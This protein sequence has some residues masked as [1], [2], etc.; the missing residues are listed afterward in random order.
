MSPFLP[1]VYPDSVSLLP[2]TRLSGMH[3]HESEV[4]FHFVPGNLQGRRSFWHHETGTR[5]GTADDNTA[6]SFPGS[7]SNRSR[8]KSYATFQ[9]HSGHRSSCKQIVSTVQG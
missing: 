9:T 4:C 8:R 3:L 5:S 1:S 2:A 7:G 6:G